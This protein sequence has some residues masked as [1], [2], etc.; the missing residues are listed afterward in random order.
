MTTIVSAAVIIENAKLL[1][2]QRPS[3]SHMSGFWEFPGG[4]VEPNESPQQALV[5][6]I[7]EELGIP[8]GVLDILDVVF[9][10]YPSKSVL[11]LFFL[12]KRLP[13]FPELQR[14]EVADIAWR[15]R[16]ELIDSQFPP[17]DISVLDKIRRLL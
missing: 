1:V 15:S 2:T 4:K 13:P 5:R 9:H 7:Q 3:Q 16:D 17:P 12:A 11:L 14:L 8:I 10:Q 6:E